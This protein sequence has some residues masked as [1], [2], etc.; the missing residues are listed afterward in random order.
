MLLHHQMGVR[1]RDPERVDRRAPR[2]RRPVRPVHH[3]RDHPQRQ[4][5]PVETR[6]GVVEVEVLRNHAAVQDQRRLDDARHARGRFQMPDI[7][8]HRTHEERSFRLASLSI[9]RG[10][11][12]G[13][14]RVAHR[15]SG[16]VGLQIVHLQGAD[17]RVGQG[18]A[19][20]LFQRGRVRHRQPR[21]RAA[22]VHRRAADHG[23]DPIAVRLR[24]AQPLEDYDPAPLAA[25]IPV[26]RSVERLA[27]PVR[28]QHHRVRAQ[29][30]DAS[31]ED[32]L[33]TARDGQ[34]RPVLLEVRHRVVD[35]HHG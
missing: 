13:L 31:V 7:R 19:H 21:A 28:R 29:F 9:D 34:I 18:R 20:H 33:H 32:R 30:V 3:R 8:L 26:R 17:S 2:T 23:P 16:P 4:T 14:D 1:P 15:G 11:G 6:V 10:N 24:L 5:I 35:R 27:L 22:V 12:V 25:H